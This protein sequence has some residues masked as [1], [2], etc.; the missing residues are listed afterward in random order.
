MLHLSWSAETCTQLVETCG[1][2]RLGLLPRRA[3]KEARQ[4]GESRRG[5][6]KGYQCHTHAPL[7]AQQRPR[8]QLLAGQSRWIGRRNGLLAGR[9]IRCRRGRTR[10]NGAHPSSLRPTISFVRPAE[11][12]G[13]RTTVKPPDAH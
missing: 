12:G 13:V 1:T 9:R 6:R 10:R 11:P 4:A 8:M 7:L 5:R 2:C 3:R